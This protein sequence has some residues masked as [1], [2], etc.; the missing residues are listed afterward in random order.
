[1]VQGASAA[2]ATA[3]RAVGAVPVEVPRAAA[4]P[5]TRLG[6]APSPTP[7]PTAAA[8]PV[9]A[10]PM[11]QSPELKVLP[12][13]TQHFLTGATRANTREGLV[14]VA[15]IS[16][17]LLATDLLVSRIAVLGTPTTHRA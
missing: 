1:V 14:A 8:F 15:G 4:N 17:V 12:R 2:H 7:E 6:T 5:F 9:P 13:K 10:E 11:G 16:R 3:L